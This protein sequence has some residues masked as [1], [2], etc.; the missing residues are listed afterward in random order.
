MKFKREYCGGMP[1]AGKFSFEQPATILDGEDEET[2]EKKSRKAKKA[3]KMAKLF[4]AMLMKIERN[5]LMRDCL[6][7]L[8]PAHREVVDLVYYDERT[9]GEVAQILAIPQG[10]VKTRMFHARKRLGELLAARGVER[11]PV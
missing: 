5:K 8:S 9:T 2:R 4:E 6:E 1:E 10:T 7:Q 3:R 11:V